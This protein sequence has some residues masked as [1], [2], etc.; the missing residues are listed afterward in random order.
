MI[1]GTRPVIRS[2]LAYFAA[3]FALGFVLGT[4]RTLWLAPRLGETGAVLAELPVML[5]A[6]W[7]C[8]R[9]IVARAALP[10]R[11][12]ALALGGLAFALLLAAEL[13]LALLLFGETAA[14]WLA[15]LARLPG[16]LGLAGQMLFGLMPAL[17]WRRPA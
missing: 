16:A 15:S 7:W 3:I 6:S 8:A 11:G 1:P 2:A 14:A 4:M 5:A 13:A 10:G 17:A 9:R 12:A